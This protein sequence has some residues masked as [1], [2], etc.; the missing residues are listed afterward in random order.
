MTQAQFDTLIFGAPRTGATLIVT[1]LRAGAWRGRMAS[2]QAA[3][4][5]ARLIMARNPQCVVSICE[6]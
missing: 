5:A 2:V 4:A 3:E 6:G 1:G